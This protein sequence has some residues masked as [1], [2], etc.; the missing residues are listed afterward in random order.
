MTDQELLALV[1]E[2]KTLF[3][4]CRKHAGAVTAE[5]I[6]KGLSAAGIPISQRD[7]FIVGL[8]H[9]IDLL[10]LRPGATGALHL[11]L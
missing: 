7:V 8:P 4:A 11:D 6:R 3:G 9:E 2:A 10:V 5:A 1:E